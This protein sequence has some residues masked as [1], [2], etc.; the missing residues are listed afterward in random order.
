MPTVGTKNSV[1]PIEDKDAREKEVV[2]LFT[3]P[4]YK[5]RSSFIYNGQVISL[6][7]NASKSENT[8][9]NK[10]SESLCPKS[11]W[12]KKAKSVISMS[13]CCLSRHCGLTFHDE[14]LEQFYKIYS[15]KQKVLHFMSILVFNF[16]LA[17]IL[18]T[19][20][21]YSY[22]DRKIPSLVVISASLVITVSVFVAFR[23]EYI[24]GTTVAVLSYLIWLLILLQIVMKLLSSNGSQEDLSRQHTG[25][26]TVWVL[27]LCYF[28]Y[29]V[30]PARRV[31]CMIFSV[32]INIAHLSILLIRC[33]LNSDTC[34]REYVFS[35]QVNNASLY[36]RTIDSILYYLSIEII[37]YI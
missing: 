15:N 33:H 25:D 5:D 23:N 7:S 9:R 8:S 12:Q 11:S 4:K 1:V 32:S 17:V 16:C 6:G 3:K 13:A 37:K 19:L 22:E 26:T 10:D 27:L 28:A 34:D 21:I 2:Q 18:M 35:T 20:N 24:A 36:R 31:F 30:L 29:V 14:S